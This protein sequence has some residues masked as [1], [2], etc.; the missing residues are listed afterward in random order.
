MTVSTIHDHP[1]VLVVDDDRMVADTVTKILDIAGFD[2]R[3]AYCGEI[4]LDVALDFDPDMVI[5]EVVMPG[6]SGIEVAI[7][8]RELAPACKILLF[9]GRAT[10]HL[11]IEAARAEN[12]EFEML[13]KPVHPRE[14]IARVRA[15]LPVPQ[16]AA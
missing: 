8:M 15:A 4:A 9:S 13:A 11:F 7:K 2:A 6:I 5:T 12:Q 16:P 14:L 3:A 10:T 1:R